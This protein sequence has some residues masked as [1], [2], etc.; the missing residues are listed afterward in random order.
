MSAVLE[1]IEQT[2][3]ALLGALA[4]RDW[5][6]I[7]DLDVNCRLCV[8][9]VLGEPEL[10]E[11]LLRIKLEE[12]LGVYRQLIEVAQA[13]QS[14][15]VGAMHQV[16]CGEG[17]LEGESLAGIGADRFHAPAIDIALLHEES[18]GGRGRSRY[19]RATMVQVDPTGSLMK[20]MGCWVLSEPRRWWSMISAMVTWSAPATAW[21][22]SL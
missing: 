16:M 5:D 18:H 12:L 11:A 14:E 13:R 2:R 8:D 20:R 15:L 4:N 3:D 21:L 7:S 19:M 17:R 10:D 1:R 9:D 6:A 22:I